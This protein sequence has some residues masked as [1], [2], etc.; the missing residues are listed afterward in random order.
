MNEENRN[1][2]N[3]LGFLLIA[4]QLFHFKYKWVWELSWVTVLHDRFAFSMCRLKLCWTELL[5][6]VFMFTWN[7]FL[8]IILELQQPLKMEKIWEWQ[9]IVSGHSKC[10]R[11]LL[12]VRLP[13]K[14]R[15]CNLEVS[16]T[17][18]RTCNIFFKLC[19]TWHNF[20]KN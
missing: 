9:F 18:I 17:F 5:S 13:N 8:F 6:I 2:N 1:L 19:K 15:P 14:H 20:L 11:K 7:Y 10:S 12:N 4:K 3:V 16:A